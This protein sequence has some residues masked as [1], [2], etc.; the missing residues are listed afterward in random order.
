[1]KYRLQGYVADFGDRT[2]NAFDL[3]AWKQGSELKY[4]G[5]RLAVLSGSMTVEL[6]HVKPGGAREV[7]AELDCPQPGE[8]FSPPFHLPD[9]DGIIVPMIVAHSEGVQYDLFFGTDDTP[10]GAY[11]RIAFL[12]EA[13]DHAEAQAMKQ[14]YGHYSRIYAPGDAAHLILAGETPS[15]DE[16][17]IT[18]APGTAADA[19]HGLALGGL[20]HLHATH[21]CHIGSQPPNPEML[22]RA[23]AFAAFAKPGIRTGTHVFTETPGTQIGDG[24]DPGSDRT[25]PEPERGWDCLPLTCLYRAEDL[26]ATP[27]LAPLSFWSSEARET[28]SWPPAPPRVNDIHHLQQGLVDAHRKIDALRDSLHDAHRKRATYVDEIFARV[29]LDEP[30]RFAH[31][32]ERANYVALS[33]LQNRHVGKRAV[34]IGNGPSLTAADL[35]RLGDTV[36]FASNKIYLI[37]DDTE[38][39]PDYYSVEDSLVMMNNLEQITALSGVTKIF[40]DTMRAFGYRGADAVF[41]PFH[42]PLSLKNPRSDPEFPG[43]GIDLRHGLHWGSTVAYSQIQ[44]A[45][46]MG[47]SEIVMIG[48]DHNYDLPKKRQGAFYVHDGERNHF[49]PEYRQP[50]ELWHQPNLDVLAV[51][52]ARAREVCAE[53]G[54]QILN[55][56]RQTRLDVFETA[57][58][59]TLF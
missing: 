3:T 33:L 17:W 7:V 26:G 55:A 13:A 38:W 8:A 36:T 15:S 18:T 14:A 2:I 34:I 10:P 42:L 25:L 22:A 57:D 39:R 29:G 11:Q 41:V 30:E 59:D 43:F 52:Y 51:S 31:D 50:G 27:A 5:A 21:L 16:P 35:D 48:I 1:M 24:F 37:F 12:F 6:F 4:F 23:T 49:H 28:P 58:F 40:P 47:C 45:A 54:I 20:G 53:R 44:L 32:L 46:F 56:S 19:A 9:M